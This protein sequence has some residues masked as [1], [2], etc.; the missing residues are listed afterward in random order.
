MHGIAAKI[1]EKI[2]MLFQDDDAHSG[3]REEKAEHHS[4]RSAADDA[5]LSGDRSARHDLISPFAGTA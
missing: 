3:A 5:T 1:A 2:R 4:G